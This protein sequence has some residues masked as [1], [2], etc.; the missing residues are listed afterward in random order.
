MSR[1]CTAV[2]F[3]IRAMFLSSLAYPHRLKTSRLC[4]LGT[5]PSKAQGRPL[6]IGWYFHSDFVDFA[7]DSNRLPRGVAHIDFFHP[8]P[9]RF[10]ANIPW[11]SCRPKYSDACCEVFSFHSSGEMPIHEGGEEIPKFDTMVS[12]LHVVR[13]KKP[14]INL[15]F[16]HP[17]VT[18]LPFRERERER[19][20]GFS[21]SLVVCI[22]FSG[23]KV[24][25][26]GRN[27]KN[28]GYLCWTL[29]L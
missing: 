14:Y 16:S 12:R 26:G 10:G 24:G 5:V 3:L 4:Q 7:V 15:P 25:G 29:T 13:Q 6:S 23:Q 2:T 28:R 1:T 22:P 18:S 8:T 19:H 9:G 21:S 20:P 27:M 11:M 17:K